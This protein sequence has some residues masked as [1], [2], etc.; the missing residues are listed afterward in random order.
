V[1]VLSGSVW[2]EQQKLT[3]SDGAADDYFGTFTAISG[4]TVLVG[5][6]GADVDG[7]TDQGA[8]YVFVRA[9]TAWTQQQKLAASDGEA[10]NYFGRSVAVLNDKALVGAD[11][12]YVNG[13]NQQGAAY[14]FGRA[15]STWTQRQKLTASDGNWWD[16][17]GYSVA[18]S[19]DTALVGARGAE[20]DANNWQ[21]AAY[22]FEYSEGSPAF[23]Q[24]LL[25]D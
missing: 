20:F 2:S 13:R 24:L 10:Y 17:F 8:A 19:G 4:D 1:F 3:A 16:W 18:V 7:R 9:G 11:Y 6:N 12:A 14:A 21:G 5:A 25:L 22:V 23:L 15:G